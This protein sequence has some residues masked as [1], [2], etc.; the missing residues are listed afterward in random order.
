MKNRSRPTLRTWQLVLFPITAL[1]Y[2]VGYS[3]ALAANSA[4]GWV[5]VW[6]GGPLLIACGVI[7]VRR[8]H[9]SELHS[10]DQHGSAPRARDE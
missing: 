1:C 5:L 10:T 3:L 8:I 2:L 4:V 6:A 9:L 7:T